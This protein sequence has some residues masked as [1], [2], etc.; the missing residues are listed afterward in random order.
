MVGRRGDMVG[1]RGGMV[2]RRGGMVGRRGDMVGSPF[3]SLKS[4]K[5]SSPELI[6]GWKAFLPFKATC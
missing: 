3:N 2:G 4:K 5:L 1:R 6:Q